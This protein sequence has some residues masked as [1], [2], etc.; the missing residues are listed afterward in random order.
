[1]SASALVLTY[2]EEKNIERCLKSLQWCDEVVVLDSY[3][4]DRT[5]E[6][7]KKLGAVVVMKE[8]EDYASQRNYGLN[9]IDYKN[10]WVLMV[11]ADEIVPPELAQEIRERIVQAPSQVTMFRI[12]RIEHFLDGTLDHCMGNIWYGRLVRRG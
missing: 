6:I 8:F 3:S 9:S 2:N 4:T 12:A 5:I 1:M 10:E 11:D 7:A